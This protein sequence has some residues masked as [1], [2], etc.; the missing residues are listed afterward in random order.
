MTHPSSTDNRR[1]ARV[2]IALELEYRSAGAFLVAYTTNLSKGGIF[3][4]T[5]APLPIGTVVSMRLRAPNMP[6]CELHGTV[7]WLRPEST[8]P[9][10]PAG[11]GIVIDT[12]A[13]QYG[14]VV[15]QI[16]F[17]FTGIQILLG[18]GEAAPRAILSRYLRSVLACRIIDFDF[19]TR[20]EMLP[21]SIDLAV[22]D[23]DSSGPEGAQLIQTLRFDARTS[24][25][26]IIALGQLERDRMRAH[27]RGA[28]EALTNPPLFA[29]LQ[30]AVIRCI[31]KPT[32]V[33]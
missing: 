22:I 18:T 3:V 2:P 1:N 5:T 21:D 23:L 25:T 32:A 17:S 30:S 31:A 8:G 27:Q 11:M 29:E 28:D 24:T 12:A 14:A 10:Q 16:A 15:D 13:E 7:A 4:D 6:P 9:G 19:A 26:P 33:R 20:P